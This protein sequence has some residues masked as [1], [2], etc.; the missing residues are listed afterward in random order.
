MKVLIDHCLQGEF[1]SAHFLDCIGEFMQGIGFIE[2]ASLDIAVKRYVEAYKAYYQPFMEEH[3]YIVENYLVNYA[4]RNLFPFGPQK[5]LLFEQRSIYTEY[6]LLVLHYSLIK[7]LLI[8]LAGY[9]QK[10]ISAKHVV[11][12]VQIFAK[13]VEHN[14]SYLR[15]AVQ[16]ITANGMN[17]TGG[18]KVLIKN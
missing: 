12:L 11:N 7:T 5:S 14:L 8:G 6:I 3:E 1:I 17:N 13:T 9:H 2:G 16:F 18:M 15:Q 4:F 10:N